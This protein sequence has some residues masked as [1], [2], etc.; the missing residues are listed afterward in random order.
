[1]APHPQTFWLEEL[2][3]VDVFSQWVFEQAKPHLGGSILEVGCGHGTYTKRLAATGERVVALDIDDRFV[4]AARQ[5][6]RDLPNVEVRRADATMEVF[7]EQFDSI[8]M[9]DVLE[10]IADD[11]AILR[12]LLEALRPGGSLI[13][14]VPAFE[15]L[16]GSMDVAVGHCRR[17]SKAKL[18][19]TLVDA[20]FQPPQIWHFNAAAI[21]GW[22]LNGVVFRRVVP[23]QTHLSWFGRILPVVKAVDRLASAYVGLSLFAVA[24]KPLVGA[25]P[26]GSLV[27]KS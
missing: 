24:H 6:T 3:R 9:L 5:A 18:A 2:D 16:F 25:P 12:K 20:G 21:P 17:Y 19:H 14:K 8:L 27:E 11:G 15:W 1:V 13:L 10:H 22:W 4:T 26:I 23:P 7:R